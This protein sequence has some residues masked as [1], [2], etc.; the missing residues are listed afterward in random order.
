MKPVLPQLLV[1]SVLIGLAGSASAVDYTFNGGVADWNT[2]GAW[3]PVGPPG[4]GSGNHAIVNSGTANITADT[5]LIQDPFIG[6]GAGTNGTVN[7]TA[8]NH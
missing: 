3:T 1:A 4:G 6:R 2:A 7:Q 8:G 5:A